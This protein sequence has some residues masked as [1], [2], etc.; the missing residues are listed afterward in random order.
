M[1]A[2]PGICGCRDAIAG[3]DRNLVPVL[4]GIVA[5]KVEIWLAMH[6]DLRAIKRVRSMFDHL[7]RALALHV[8]ASRNAPRKRGYPEWFATKPE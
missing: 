5:F 2:K 4:P 8:A 1:P 7:A 6:E 3:S